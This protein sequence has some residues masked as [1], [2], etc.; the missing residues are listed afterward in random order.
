M[1]ELLRCQLNDYIAQMKKNR[2]ECLLLMKEGKEWKETAK[3]GSGIALM[4]DAT[5]REIKKYR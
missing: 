1:I 3:K 2:A 4:I 5:L